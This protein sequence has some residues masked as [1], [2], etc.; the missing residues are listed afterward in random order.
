PGTG[1]PFTSIKVTVMVDV[2]LPLATILV[3]LATTEDWAAVAVP[4]VKVTKAVWV[5]VMVSLESVAVR[6]AAPAVVDFTVKLATPLALVL[7]ET[8]AMVSVAPRS[9]ASVTVLPGARLPLASFKVT[10]IAEVVPPSAVTLPGL[11]AT[12]D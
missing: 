11:A 12:V 2:V 6:V 1:L 7:P 8:V 9:E 4:A 3:G 5:T 10:V